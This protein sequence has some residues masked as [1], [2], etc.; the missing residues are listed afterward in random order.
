[1]KITV[2]KHRIYFDD[3]AWDL[4]TRFARKAHRTNKQIVITAL[5]RG[6]K[7]AQKEDSKRMDPS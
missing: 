5:R 4:I 7:L 3:E 6:V 2:R 1:M